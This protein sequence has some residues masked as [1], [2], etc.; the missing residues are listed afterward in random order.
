MANK[1]HVA[2]EAPSIIDPST[3]HGAYWG[4]GQQKRSWH[5]SKKSKKPG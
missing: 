3:V 1:L 5:A 2:G 4:F